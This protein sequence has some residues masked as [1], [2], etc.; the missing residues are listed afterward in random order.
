[1]VEPIGRAAA[2][3][4]QGTEGRAEGT[5]APWQTGQGRQGER[6]ADRTHRVQCRQRVRQCQSEA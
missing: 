2:G 3:R 6:R 4:D 5:D 1:M